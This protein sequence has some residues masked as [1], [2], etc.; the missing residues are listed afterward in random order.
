MAL[1][2]R[3]PLSA[4]DPIVIQSLYNRDLNPRLFIYP[5]VVPHA[6]REAGEMNYRLEREVQDSNDCFTVRMIGEFYPYES[7]G[8]VFIACIRDSEDIFGDKI[9]HL[10][11]VTAVIGQTQ[12]PGVYVTDRH[13]DEFLQHIAR[14]NAQESA[15]A[16][17]AH[18]WSQK[19]VPD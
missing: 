14:L 4:R 7:L 17:D 12:L 8:S 11:L 1:I 15:I 18:E 9:A 16:R 6:T 3:P 19:V 5:E 2:G 10:F 13:L